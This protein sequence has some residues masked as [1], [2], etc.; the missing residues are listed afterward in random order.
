M[1]GVRRRDPSA[2]RRCGVPMSQI[3][4]FLIHPKKTFNSWWR[5]RLRRIDVLILFPKIAIVS[6]NQERLETALLL[7]M[8]EDPA[9]NLD[10]SREEILKEAANLSL[11]LWFTRTQI[12]NL[13]EEEE[14]YQLWKNRLKV[15]KRLWGEK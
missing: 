6:S 15:E 3:F 14:F 1:P 9:W 5:K 12:G 7:R 8:H 13:E 2:G 11:R 4:D 10:Y